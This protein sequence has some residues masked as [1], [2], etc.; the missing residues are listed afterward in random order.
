MVY[1]EWG[2]GLY[3]LCWIKFSNFNDN[4]NYYRVVRVVYLV[5]LYVFVEFDVGWVLVSLVI[6]LVLRG[7]Y[8]V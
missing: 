4:I 2:V 3:F 6:R 5:F 1:N 8:V 7:F